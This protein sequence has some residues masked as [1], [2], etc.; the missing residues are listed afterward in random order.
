MCEVRPFRVNTKFFAIYRLSC[1][2]RTKF[3][4]RATGS[5]SLSL[6]ETFAGEKKGVGSLRRRIFARTSRGVYLLGAQS[7]H[8]RR[9]YALLGAAPLLRQL[10]FRSA[11]FVTQAVVRECSKSH[12]GT[13]V[14]A[15]RRKVSKVTEVTFSR[16]FR[17]RCEKKLAFHLR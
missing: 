8:R 7:R 9:V 17:Q 6:Y 3:P 5:L 12:G 1:V 14:A 13:N 4:P 15:Q 2:R 10:C 11:Y 16:E